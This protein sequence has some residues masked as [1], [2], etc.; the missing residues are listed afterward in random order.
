MQRKSQSSYHLSAS[1]EH[2]RPSPLLTHTLKHFYTTAAFQSSMW[3]VDDIFVPPVVITSLCLDTVS[4][5]MGVRHLLLPAQLPGTHW[6]MICVIRRLALTVSDVYLF[7]LIWKICTRGL[8]RTNDVKFSRSRPQRFGL[9]LGLEALASASPSNIWPR[10][11]LDLDVLVCN[12]AFFGQKSCK[13]RE[14]C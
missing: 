12:R 9:A 4:A 14:F 11:G 3:P 2:C 1:Q 5:R 8:V 10:P 6:A 13:I 7:I